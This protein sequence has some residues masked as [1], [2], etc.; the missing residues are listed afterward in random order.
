MGQNCG[1]N[2]RL[3]GEMGPAKD[4]ALSLPELGEAHTYP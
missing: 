2:L 1:Q 3:A 4:Q